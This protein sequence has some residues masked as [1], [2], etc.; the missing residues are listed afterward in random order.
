MIC[1]CL[2]VFSLQSLNSYLLVRQDKLQ[3]LLKKKK[4]KSTEKDGPNAGTVSK[5]KGVG[6]LKRVRCSGFRKTLALSVQ[7]KAQQD[8][9]TLKLPCRWSQSQEQCM[10]GKESKLVH[11]YIHSSSVWS[12]RNL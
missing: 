5:D 8:L 2:W 4:K 7:T 9:K 10:S 3:P 12:A 1:L 11:F 6:K